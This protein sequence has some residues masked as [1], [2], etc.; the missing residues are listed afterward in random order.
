MMVGV[1]AKVSSHEDKINKAIVETAELR[2]KYLS[3][4]E[5]IKAEEPLFIE[6]DGERIPKELTELASFKKGKVE[7]FVLLDDLPI[8]EE[9]KNK[10]LDLNSAYAAEYKALL[11]NKHSELL[12]RL[13]KY[14]V[15]FKLIY[16]FYNVLNGFYLELPLTD[17]AKLRKI[18]GIKEIQ[19]PTLLAIDDKYALDIIRAPQVWTSPGVKGEGQVIAI[20]DT[21]VDYLHPDLGAG[22]GAGFKVIGGY[23]FGDMDSDPM[24]L[25]G[26]GTH[27]AG[28]AAAKPATAT[29]V[30]G[31]A[32][33]AKIVAYKIVK[34]GEGVAA[35]GAIAAAFED[36]VTFTGPAGE[37]VTAANLSFG[38]AGGF[39]AERLAHE[40]AMDNA[41]TAGIFVAGSAGN[42]W[43]STIQGTFTS[44]S[45]RTTVYPP[46]I[47]IVASP[48]TAGLVTM[49]AASNNTHM[50]IRDTF[51]VVEPGTTTSLRRG[52]YMIGADSKDPVVVF[53]K[54]PLE[55]V[56]I[57]SFGNIQANYAG[58]D[59]KGKIA[60]VSR[61]GLPGEDA[62]FVNKIRLAQTNGAAMIIV[63]NDAARGELLLT[64]ATAPDLRIPRVFSGYSHGL[65]LRE[66]PG[67]RIIF[68]GD[69]SFA[70]TI[71]VA[72]PDR[73][74]TF[75]SW[76]LTPEMG[77]KP[78]IT[79]PGSPIWNTNTRAMGS[80]AFKSGTSMSAP[81][82]AGV[83]AL[84][85][86]H[87]PTFTPA[88]IKT[89]LVNTAT[90]LPHVGTI[91]PASPRLQ[92]GG[93]VDIPR[94]LATPA[95]MNGL[96]GETF[97]SLGDTDGRTSMS[98]SLRVRN[99]GATALTYTPSTVVRRTL[100]S[101]APT[102]YAGITASFTRAGAP[103]TSLTIPAG[104]EATF[105]VV[106]SIGAITVD[107][108]F[109]EGFVTL[110]PTAGTD[111]ALS[112][113]Y[114]MFVGDFQD[115][116]YRNPAPGV[117]AFA[118]NMVIDLPRDEAGPR[119]VSPAVGWS[120]FGRTWLYWSPDEAKVGAR[121]Y[122]LGVD[123]TGRV[124][125]KG[126]VAFSPN[127][128]GSQDNLWPG[129]SFMRGTPELK[130]Q[131]RG[132]ALTTPL[133]IFTENFVRKNRDDA[134]FRAGWANWWLWDGGGLAEGDYFMDFV[135][136]VPSD[137]SP[138]DA[139]TTQTVTLPF[140]IDVTPP[141]V[142][143]GPAV[144]S[145]AGLILNWTATDPVKAG[146]SGIWGYQLILVPRVGDVVRSAYLAPTA[147][148]HTFT[149]IPDAGVEAILSVWDNAGNLT[150]T[151]FTRFERSVTLAADWNFVGIASR[152]ANPDPSAVFPGSMVYYFDTA[153]GKLLRATTIEEGRGYWVRPTVATTVRYLESYPFDVP[154]TLSL[155]RGWNQLGNLFG[156][157]LTTANLLIGYGG[158]NYTY[159]EAVASLLISPT[160]YTYAPGTGYSVT[161]SIAPR[162]GFMIEAKTPITLLLRR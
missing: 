12:A 91:V 90:V 22:F 130:I 137:P 30:S 53:N 81:Y 8:V 145:G 156:T 125:S 127:A 162:A 60:V 120:W 135:A 80:Y 157:T 99:L 50:D 89:A 147:T 10:G 49:V 21:G 5:E 106:V 18:S 3:E 129:I 152:P 95:L 24:D 54:A 20:V 109:A 73:I 151:S 88:M 41:V 67:K 146:T 16:E 121:L 86:Q 36:M 44:P 82:I 79:A 148:T 124:L 40:I 62:T 132:G 57:P 159:D 32:P 131:V 56:A 29:G 96:G 13:S 6:V 149:T 46:D 19:F 74:A 27:V 112:I 55:Y 70:I 43:H 93:R 85:K 110:T 25:H 116:R 64:M 161:T 72:D 9:L 33:E 144:R 75:S 63:H 48:N 77:P 98:F 34:G 133:N 17:L 39:Y 160:I 97:I 136:E 92:G 140:K 65:W 107:N 113:P 155:G 158:R 47:G 123:H 78:E 84:V 71:P 114:V 126:N 31:V 111:I 23:D 139:L 2:N 35:S 101:R 108:T 66:N 104:G 38:A 45:G 59:V 7:V 58:L 143:L 69:T 61:G 4:I 142:T 51:N 150:T 1:E 141:V 102:T 28:I 154:P 94:A 119:L 103:L 83:G 52:T 117:T 68:D 87:R 15:N 115:V 14:E 105:E 100:A 42:N 11:S 118:S 122:A 76:G 128:D 153:R 138:G 37:K 26:H 134:L